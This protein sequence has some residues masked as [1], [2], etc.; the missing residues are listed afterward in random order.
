MFNPENLPVLIDTYSGGGIGAKGLRRAGFYVI[1]VDHKRKH[2]AGNEF[3]QMD[4]IQ[5]LRLFLEGKILQGVN[6]SALWGSPPCQGYSFA[7]RANS[8]WVSY[9]QGKDT[10]KLIEPTRELFIAS[11]LPYV[12]ENVE[13]AKNHLVNPK[14]LCGK[15]FNIHPRRHR[16][17]ETNFEIEMPTHNSCRGWDSTYAKEHGLD[18]RDMAVAGKSRRKGSVELWRKFMDANEDHSSTEITEGI[19]PAYA[20]YIGEWLMK[21]V[22][23]NIE[24]ANNV[25]SRLFTGCAIL[26]ATSNKSGVELPAVGG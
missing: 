19:P 5:F 13:G 7:T 3:I 26:P 10:P 22:R 23:R 6:V 24:Q 4:V 16:L 17:F 21:Q 15:M 2:Y 1:G 12:I 11:G 25:C 14:L 8:K 20:Q 9:S 18:I